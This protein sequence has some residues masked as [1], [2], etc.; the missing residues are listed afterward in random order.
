LDRLLTDVKPVDRAYFV[1]TCNVDGIGSGYQ[2]AGSK[3]VIPAQAT[4]KVD[5]RLVPDQDPQDIL[6]K[7]RRHLEANGFGDIE[8]EELGAEP[9]GVTEADAAVVK[10]TAEIGE[11]V[12][13]KPARIIPL[14]GGTT[15]MFLFTQVGV[16]VI[17]PGVGWGAA[18]RAHSPN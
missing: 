13:G 2:G 12:Y 16:P 10:L 14:T 8:V 15:P 9:P 11:E 7:L 1:P 3:T 6:R 5:F 17:A 4:A 18:N